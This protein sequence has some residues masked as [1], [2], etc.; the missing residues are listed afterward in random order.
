MSTD[1]GIAIIYAA[2]STQDKHGSIAGQLADCRNVAA[3]AGLEVV[4][5][6]SDENESAYSGDRGPGL[7]AAMA[8][9]ER[10]CAVSGTT[11]LIVQH[12]DRLARGDA[13]EARHLIEIVLWAL[14]AGV[15]L[16]SVQDPEILAG[17]DMAL[18]LGAIGGMRNHEDSRRK[19]LAVKDGMKR[20]AGRGQANGGPRPYGFDWGPAG[21]GLVVRQAEAGV[22]RRIYGEY[23][24]G[25]GQRA[26]SRDLTADGIPTGHRGQWHQGTVSRILRNPLYVGSVTLNGQTFDGQ[27]EAIVDEK[28]FSQAQALRTASGRPRGGRHPSGGHLFTK[29]HLRCGSCGEAMIPVSKPAGRRGGDPYTAY[30]CYGRQRLGVEHCSQPNLKRSLVDGAVWSYFQKVALDVDATRSAIADAAALRQ[31][32]VDQLIDQ[33]ERETTL[34]DERLQRIRTDYVDGRITAEDY[35][36]FRDQLTGELEAASASAGTLQARRD[37][38]Q[39]QLAQVDIEGAMLSELAAIRTQ[40]GAQTESRCAAGSGTAALRAC[41]RRLF[42]RFELIPRGSFGVGPVGG[43]DSADTQAG[44]AA[45]RAYSQ[46]PNVGASSNVPHQC[47]IVWS[48]AEDLRAGPDFWLLP[49][50]RASAADLSQT[51]G[52]FPA[53]RRAALELRGND[54]EGLPL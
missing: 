54:A 8:E 43:Q 33:A 2:K 51:G 22:V 26:I 12:S 40:V 41:L 34:A 16:R 44:R 21:G 11:T 47:G 17:G 24:A 20:R 6:F 36:G 4:A 7:K 25:R 49:V 48:G 13:K 39:A 15:T 30:A 46:R 29:G 35:T 18:L 37:E 31:A 50:V 28:S 52:D 42:V 5:E 23:L 14:K 27:H 53:I 10:I 3:R 45:G 38:L 9:C 19:S 1:N 32:E